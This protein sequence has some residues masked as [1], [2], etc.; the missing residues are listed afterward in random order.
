MIPVSKSIKLFLG[1]VF[2]AAL[3]L[4]M[5]P[6][7]FQNLR[8]VRYLSGRGVDYG[9][10]ASSSQLCQDDWLR[11]MLLWNTSKPVELNSWKMYLACGHDYLAILHVV[12]SGNLALAESAS[13]M[14][15]GDPGVW[16][17][18]G[19]I[20]IYA[21]PETAAEQFRKGIDLDPSNGTAW[22]KLGNALSYTKKLQE[23]VDSF[24]TCCR[25]GDPGNK[26]CWGAGRVY[27]RLGDIPSAIH[28][29][30]QSTLPLALKRAVDLEK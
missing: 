18:L 2:G 22:C 10:G 11:T 3:I 23:S 28:A 30:R 14:Y 8:S 21:D 6:E 7:L 24:L 19:D 4:F 9:Y 20:T 26:G 1:L 15:P 5:T 16:I 27:E 25:M 17:W 29:Y 13:Q 12:Q